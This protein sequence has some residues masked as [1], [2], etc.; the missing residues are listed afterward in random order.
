M[1]GMIA[2]LMR[3][4]TASGCAAS[5]R[6]LS[7]T[8]NG[9]LPQAEKHAMDALD[10]QPLKSMAEESLVAHGLNVARNIGSPGFSLR[11]RAPAR[12]G[13]LRN[14]FFSPPGRLGLSAGG[15]PRQLAAIIDDGCP[16]FAARRCAGADAVLP[17]ED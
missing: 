13:V 17:A 10:V 14:F 11:P 7:T 8:G 15:L 9:K 4:I 1:G 5:P 3:C 2:Q 6:S 16:P 12:T